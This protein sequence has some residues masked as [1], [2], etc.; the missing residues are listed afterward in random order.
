V[1]PTSGSVCLDKPSGPSSACLV[2]S[3]THPMQT[4]LACFA[5]AEPEGS[6]CAE[7]LHGCRERLLTIQGDH[8]HD[9]QLCS[10]TCTDAGMVCHCCRRS[11]AACMHAAL[12]DFC[13]ASTVHGMCLLTDRQTL[14]CSPDPCMLYACADGNHAAGSAS[15]MLAPMSNHAHNCMVECPAAV[16]SQQP[17]A[18][19]QQT[20]RPAAS[21]PAA[22]SSE[23]ALSRLLIPGI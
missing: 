4:F 9:T 7:Q 2:D 18:S 22:S 21:R 13:E 10:K 1:R 23:T 16:S 15:H 8:R 19:S 17:A 12:V 14:T 3:T 6:L 5:A 20:S 11:R